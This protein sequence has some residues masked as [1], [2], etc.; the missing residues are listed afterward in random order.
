MNAVYKSSLVDSFRSLVN[1][2]KYWCNALT[3]QETVVSGHRRMS[4][5]DSTQTAQVSNDHSANVL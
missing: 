3:E 1:G 2:N 4:S 5:N